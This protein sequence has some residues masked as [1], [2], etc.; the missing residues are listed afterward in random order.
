MSTL[1]VTLRAKDGIV[2]AGD[3]RGTVGDPRGLTAVRDTETKL[4]QLSTHAG[5]GISGSSELAASLFD[6][7]KTKIEADSL[8]YIDEIMRKAR[9]VA[10]A[11][12]DDWFAKFSMDK[13]PSLALILCGYEKVKGKSEPKTYLL[14]SN[15]DFAPQLFPDGNTLVGVVQYAVYLMHRF[16]NPLMT[17]AQA[18]RLAVYLISET[19]TQDPKV[20]GPIKMA[21]I[22][23]SGLLWVGEDEIKKIIATNE[24]QNEQMRAFFKA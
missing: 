14:G 15:L 4:F 8:V 16:Y 11:S 21:R 12:Y 18:S 9:E 17:C 19:A 10:K 1:I 6:T 5:M 24:E 23:P 3:S 13:R 7:L 20:G 22:R 2:L